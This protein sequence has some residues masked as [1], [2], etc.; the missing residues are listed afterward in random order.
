MPG[1]W[2]W[3][4]AGSNTTAKHSRRGDFQLRRGIGAGFMNRHGVEAFPKGEST[5]FA[6]G[7]G[8]AL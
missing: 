7:L 5:S 6:M 8:P 4:N 2:P 3:L 1:I